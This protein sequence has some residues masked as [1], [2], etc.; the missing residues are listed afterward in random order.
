M[1]SSLDA[2]VIEARPAVFFGFFFRDYVVVPVAEH[3]PAR[4]VVL[5]AS[6]TLQ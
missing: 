3:F 2:E 4:H 1:G 6:S 5:F